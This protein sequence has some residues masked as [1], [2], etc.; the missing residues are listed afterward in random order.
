MPDAVAVIKRGTGEVVLANPSFETSGQS[1]TAPGSPNN[2][3]RQVSVSTLTSGGQLK[4]RP[5]RLP[6]PFVM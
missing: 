5:W 1:I 6:T 2:K 3:G 4:R